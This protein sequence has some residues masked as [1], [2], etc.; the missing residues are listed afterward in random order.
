MALAWQC[1]RCGAVSSGGYD[2]K[3]R[4]HTPPE[5]W[6]QFSGPVRGSQG[7]RSSMTT[8]IC[9]TCD[10]DLYQWLTHPSRKS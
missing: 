6:R 3:D 5:D 8:V 10:D 4:Q 7:A 9:D 2:Q 1:D